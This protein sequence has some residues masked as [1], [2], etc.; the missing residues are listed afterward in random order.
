MAYTQPAINYRTSYS[1]SNIPLTGV[2]SAIINRGR[3]RFQDNFVG[4][5]CEIELIP[6][7]S[8]ATPIA[9][10]QWLDVRDTTGTTGA[11]FTGTITD[12][13]RTYSMPYNSG[14]GYAPGDRIRIT[15]TG[16]TGMLGVG[17]GV[18]ISLG[19]SV[20]A[21]GAIAYCASQN[22][23]GYWIFGGTSY[24]LTQGGTYSNY[25]TLD[26]INQWCRTGQIFIDD[27]DSLFSSPAISI[28][29]GA[30]LGRSATFTDTGATGSTTYK[31]NHI[32]YQSSVQTA[33]TQ[34]AV[35]PTGLAT[36][37]AQTGS[38]PYATLNY[39]TLNV[40]T[41]DAANLANYLLVTN[42]QATATPFIVGTDTSVQSNCM[43]VTQ[44]MNGDSTQSIPL[45]TIVTVTFRGVTV[46]AQVQGIQSFFYPDRAGFQLF[47]SPSL[48]QAFTLNSTSNGVLDTNRLGFP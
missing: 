24:A 22:N 48:G 3:Q 40:S 1:A 45:G 13:N 44:V 31:F 16:S 33:F 17:N 7:T 2:Q 10:G 19:G 27:F 41:A 21:A 47:L 26:L 30:T 11:W 29:A 42:N 15:A 28:L 9:V 35:T 38:A 36:Q 23:M 32:E 20:T 4:S 34:V 8:Y 14:T 37:T 5:Q 18:T 25:Q 39:Q 43:K 12:V 6:A 46:Y